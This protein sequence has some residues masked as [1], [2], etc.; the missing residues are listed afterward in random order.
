MIAKILI[1]DDDHNVLQS[2]KLWLS[3]EGFEVFSADNGDSAILTIRENKIDVVLLDMKLNNETGISIARRINEVDKNLKIIVITGF[4]SYDSAVESMKTGAFDYLSKGST[5]EKI[6]QTILKALK[7]KFEESSSNDSSAFSDQ[8]KLIV[9]C[10][11]SLIVDQLKIFTSSHREFNLYKTFKSFDLPKNAD[12]FPTIDIALIC[13]SCFL[14]DPDNIYKLF[15]KLY[16]EFPSIKPV[17]QN[18]DFSD[19]EKVE[20]VRIGVKGFFSREIN[21]KQLYKALSSIHNG[22]IWIS[23]KIAN[24]AIQN[25]LDYS[26]VY[27]ARENIKSVLSQR[28]MEVLKTLVLG[29][30]NKEIA[31]KLFISEPTV[32]THINRIFKKLGVKSRTQAVLVALDEKLL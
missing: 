31:D 27:L 22:E 28:E 4:P 30:K 18:E 29:L 2:M 1:V 26:K 6:L 19:Q 10:K 21:T 5:N 12:Y 8:I 3:S 15:N 32:K 14:K 20:L 11:H 17:I 25:R 24:L 23:R 13:A 7:V 16:R 9:F